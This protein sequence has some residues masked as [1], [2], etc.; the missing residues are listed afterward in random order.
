MDRRF[1]IACCCHCD[2]ADP[3]F[4]TL[5]QHATHDF[6]EPVIASTN[7]RCFL[8]VTLQTCD[9]HH[10][11]ALTHMHVQQPVHSNIT[12]NICAHRYMVPSLLRHVSGA[13][14]ALSKLLA[15]AA[16]S[17]ICQCLQQAACC[18]HWHIKCILLL[19][20]PQPPTVL[21]LLFPVARFDAATG[22]I[23]AL[24]RLMAF[25]RRFVQ[26]LRVQQLP[27]HLDLQLLFNAMEHSPASLSVSYGQRCVGMDYDRAA[28]GASLAD[29]RC[30][31]LLRMGFLQ[32]RSSQQKYSVR[33]KSTLYIGC[34]RSSCRASGCSA[35]PAC[36]GGAQRAC[37]REYLLAQ[38]NTCSSSSSSGGMM[39][40]YMSLVAHE[41]S[42]L[43]VPCAWSCAD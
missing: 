6:N 27:S 5:N 32:A 14:Q 23:A 13:G 12:L 7:G 21:V 40:C 3:V 8:R 33:S 25:S 26:G 4:V 15:A 30:A 36:Q 18:K 24:Q 31:V 43:Q 1:L 39:S 41:S 17:L 28:F 19:H 16:C 35:G 2:I 38:A 29:C 11:H 37:S 42:V 20:S 9:S 34:P 22:D 10:V